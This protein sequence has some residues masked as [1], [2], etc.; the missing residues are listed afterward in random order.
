MAVIGIYGL[1]QYPFATRT[2][3]TGIR[4]AT[5]AQAGEIFRMIIREGLALC[6]AA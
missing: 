6:L 4:M 5:G 2:P 1:I 3:K